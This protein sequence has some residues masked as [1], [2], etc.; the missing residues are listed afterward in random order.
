MDDTTDDLLSQARCSKTGVTVATLLLYF[1]D[2]LRHAVKPHW[3][4]TTRNFFF[5]SLEWKSGPAK[6]GPAGPLPL[7]L[8]AVANQI[9]VSFTNKPGKVVP[10]GKTPTPIP[11][12]AQLK[13]L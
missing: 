6:T 5:F 1:N 2:F 13:L 10:G 8:G 7:A 3:S 12:L 4:K 11:V 9:I